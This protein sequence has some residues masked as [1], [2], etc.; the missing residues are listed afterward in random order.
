MSKIH[1]TILLLIFTSGTAF[2]QSTGTINGRIVDPAGAVVPDA[3]VTATNAGTGV[4]RT[5]TSNADGLYN[6]AALEP[7]VYDIKVD[8]MGFAPSIRQGATLITGSTLTLDFTLV[9]AT[10]TQQVEVTGETALVETTTSEVSGSLQTSEVQALPMLNRN[11]VGL[12]TLVPGVRPTLNVNS[13]KLAFGGA[14]SVGGSSGRNVELE[15]D[16][17]AT[18][19][20]VDGG[21]MFNVSIEGIQEFKV[22]AHEFGAQYGRTDGGVVLM[23]TKSGTNQ[24]HG[25]AFAYG[26]S[27]SMTA[28]DYFTKQSGFPNP[29]YD[30]EQ[31]GGS[32]GGPIRKDKLFFFGAIERIQQDN[33]KPYPASAYNNAVLLKQSLQA[34]GS[35]GTGPFPT[36]ACALCV[37]IGN[38]IVP[39]QASP[40]TVG[41]LMY[42]VK[43]DYQ[44][45]A[46]HS[47]FVRAAQEHINDFNDLIVAGNIGNTPHP[48]ANPTGSNVFDV[49]GGYSIVGSETWIIGNNSVNTFAVQG[50]HLLTSQTCHCGTAGPIWASQNMQFPSISVGWPALSTDQQFYQDTVQFKDGFARQVGRHALRVG[51]DFSFFPLLGLMLATQHGQTTFFDD[52]STIVASQKAW[53]AN[54]KGCTTATCGREPEGFLTP[55]AVSQIAVSDV[56][57][58]G[59]P[60]NT[61]TLGAKQLGLYV[62]DDFKVKPRLTLNLGLRYDLDI[63]FY[64]QTQY[65]NNRTYLVLKAIGSPY[66]KLPQT[67][68]KDISPRVGFAWDFT[69]DGKN[70]LRASFGVFFDQVVAAGVNGQNGQEK[71][72]L[73]N[74]ASNYVNSNVGVGQLATYVYGVSALPAG[75]LPGSTQFIPGAS[76]GGSWLAP[77]LNDPYNEQSHVGYTR[78]LSASTVLSADFTHILGLRE[79]RNYQINPIEGA[80]DPN[81]ASYNTCGAPA[82]FRRLQCAFQ[83]LGEPK[84]LGGITLATSTNRS[85]YN[86][87]TIHF[88]QRAR[89]VTFQATYTLSSAYAFGGGIAGQTGGGGNA[90]V[91]VNPNEPFG[92]GEWG[93]ALTDERHR[94]VLSGVFSLPWGLQVSPVFQIASAPPYNLTAG[95]DLTGAGQAG[96][97]RAI[98][99]ATGQE[100]SINAARGTATWDLDARVTKFF[101]LWSETRRIGFFAEFYNITNK[102]NFGNNYNG[103]ATSPTYQQPFGYFNN[104]LTFPTSRQVQL[105]A[106]FIF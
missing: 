45:N 44:I 60:A 22:L 32:I 95:K 14:I 105:G 87:L 92:P 104:G 70:V 4:A 26:R 21:T 79:F 8:K 64:N 68:T 36:P 51:G 35:P 41:D 57:L 96:I 102:A 24:L 75:L 100:Y 48:D 47:L 39:V 86:D 76:T 82:G 54:P 61:N 1:L 80:W 69:G 13:N 25:T 52:P 17:V 29:P 63:N 49:D 11:Y 103:I 53:A 59:P 85:Q 40:Q 88:E 78:Q 30:R 56:M 73:A 72:T 84:I 2:A 83:A 10:T 99:P 55:G 19:D 16:G 74:Q 46:R 66:G 94:V 3:R 38:A 5:T 9:V 37:T 71:P 81:A 31:F 50:N 67:P 15:V 91:P 18:R 62:G 20:D 7:A 97:D 106:R 90:V 58:G 27:D 93:P 77:N 42:T 89:R 6:F 98:N 12:V 101:N 43:A 28:I 33:V 34:L 65:A 23:T